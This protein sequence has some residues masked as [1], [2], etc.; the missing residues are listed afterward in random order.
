MK[1]LL[2]RHKKM[3]TGLKMEEFDEIPYFLVPIPTGFSKS[4][5]VALKTPNLDGGGLQ[6]LARLCLEA[7]ENDYSNRVGVIQL[8][9]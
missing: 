7:D 4:L 3:T 9:C 5:E 2:L 6:C 1:Y 8:F